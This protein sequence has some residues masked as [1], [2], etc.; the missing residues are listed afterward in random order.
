MKYWKE[1]FPN[2]LETA[3]L[4]K[5]FVFWVRDFKFWLLAYFL[6]F[7][8]YAK[9]QKDWTTFILDI[10]QWSPFGVFCFCDSP[11]IQRGD[12][13]KMFDINV[14]QSFW[15]FAYIKKIKKKASSQNLKSLTQKTKIWC[16]NALSRKFGRYSFQQKHVFSTWNGQNNGCSHVY[17]MID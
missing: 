2:L 7:F 8:D 6:I 10:L 17:K 3:L 12:H 4:C 15:N 14:V 5:I 16:N 1:Y 11:K 9:F 13:C